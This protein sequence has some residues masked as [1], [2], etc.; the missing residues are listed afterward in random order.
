MVEAK[1]VPSFFV[2]IIIVF[3][4]IFIYLLHDFRQINILALHIKHGL[5]NDFGGQHLISVS[6]S[7]LRIITFNDGSRTRLRTLVFTCYA[8]SLNTLVPGEILLKLR[9]WYSQIYRA[10]QNLAQ[11][12]PIVQVHTL[13][14]L[15]LS[16]FFH[17]SSICFLSR[18]PKH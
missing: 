17:R 7:F 6:L 1:K 18:F 8:D 9:S 10:I 13:I 15:V 11:M 2:L 5:A 14:V 3:L 12:L 16:N 4:L